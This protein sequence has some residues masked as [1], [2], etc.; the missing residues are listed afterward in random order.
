MRQVYHVSD[1]TESRA[2]LRGV[3]RELRPE[4]A[5]DLSD[6]HA[7]SGGVVLDLVATQPP[8]Q[9]VARIRMREIESA[10]A[11]GRPHGAGL[12]ERQADLLRPQQ[13]EEPPLLAV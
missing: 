5:L 7:F 6:W 13:L 9:E 2:E 8:E 3:I 4:P 10:D 11:G 12:G 1:P